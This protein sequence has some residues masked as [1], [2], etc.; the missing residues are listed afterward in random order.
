M[1]LWTAV[2]AWLVGGSD[3]SQKSGD[4]PLCSHLPVSVDPMK[5]TRKPAVV[6]IWNP[7]TEEAEAGGSC[8]GTIELKT[9]KKEK[10]L[11]SPK[12]LTI[13]V[14]LAPPNSVYKGL[15]LEEGHASAPLSHSESTVV[16][17][18]TELFQLSCLWT[19]WGQEHF[20]VSL[21]FAESS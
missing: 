4:L 5:R 6:L 15:G 20:V 19:L 17:T 8:V 10:Y 16:S 12:A 13:C 11:L 9:N 3:W 2:Y 7:S 18:G 21:V 1:W 14:E